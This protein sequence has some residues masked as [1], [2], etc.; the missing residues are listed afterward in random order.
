[1]AR[2]T[3]LSKALTEEVCKYLRGG[4]HRRF[5]AA[6]VSIDESQFSRW[7]HRGA[8]ED[9]GP[10]REFYLAVNDAEAT[11]A[12]SGVEGMKAA[13][14]HNPKNWQFLLSRRFPG[15]FGRQDNVQQVNPED[16]AQQEAA[17]RALLIERLEKFFPEADPTPQE[18]AKPPAAAPNAE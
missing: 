12:L 11:F 13:A 2:P 5:A 10:F 8:G 17:T 1:M 7:F 6:K 4:A 16:K 18:A 3:K 9:K 15:E 14:A